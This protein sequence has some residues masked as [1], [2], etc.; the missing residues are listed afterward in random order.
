V[1]PESPPHETLRESFGFSTLSAKRPHVAFVID[2]IGDASLGRGLGSRVP[3]LHPGQWNCQPMFGVYRDRVED[4]HFYAEAMG[5][6]FSQP[7]RSLPD[8]PRHDGREYW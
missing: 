8:G 4:L 3:Y 5:T 2:G 6:K 1:T 7:C